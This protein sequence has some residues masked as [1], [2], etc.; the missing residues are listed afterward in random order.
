MKQ[1]TCIVLA[2][3]VILL[4]SM[5]LASFAAAQSVTDSQVANIDV[6]TIGGGVAPNVSGGAFEPQEIVQMFANVTSSNMA[7][8]NQNV[9]FYV[10]N[11]NGTLIALRA[12]LTNASGIASAEYRMPTPDPS[13]PEISFGTWSITASVS[14][15]QTTVTDTTNF[16]FGYLSAIVNSNIQIP[17]SIQTLEDLPIEITINNLGS[18][19]VWSELD[20]TLFDQAQ[21]PIGSYS[22]TNTDPAQ[23]EVINAS[24]FIP[25]WAFT[26]QGTAC[27]CL[28]ASDGTPMGPENVVNFQ[29]TPNTATVAINPTILVL[30]EYTWGGLAALIACFAA[31][32]A[33]T[34]VKK[35]VKAHQKH[36]LKLQKEA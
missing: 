19:T 30:P 5:S 12:A 33:L 24:I 27:I 23:N 3:T 1:K 15:A 11:P 34:V 26:G 18:S 21:V 20:I 35:G 22:T 25:S 28:L 13:T 6:F 8:V 29:I 10:E 31:F 4:F 16:T 7:L 36:K 17:A 14:V 2:V 32:M 9:A